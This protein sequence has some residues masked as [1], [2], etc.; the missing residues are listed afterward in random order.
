MAQFERSAR[1]NRERSDEDK[2]G[3]RR[4]PMFRRKVCRFCADK[5]LKIDY[6]DLRTL[7]RAEEVRG[8]GTRMAACARMHRKQART[9]TRTGRL[10]ASRAGGKRAGGRSART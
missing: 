4:R 1:P 9:M 2:G 5:S 10:F 3:Q 6:K 8:D 7:T